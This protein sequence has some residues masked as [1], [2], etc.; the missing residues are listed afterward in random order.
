[1][2]SINENSN[3]VKQRHGC[4]TTWIVIMI[5]S[6]SL[7]AIIYLFASDMIIDNLPGDVATS[8][9]I[10]LGIIGIANVVFSVLL[11]QW[12]KFAFWGFAITSLVAFFINLSIE[13]G[14]GQSVFGLF[15]IAI[16]YGIMQIKKDNVT[17]WSNLE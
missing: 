16:L 11:L 12:K 2:E 9:I 8:M 17:A 6:N 3:V 5:I 1:M 4:V 14:L 10:L 7:L 13:V 15:G